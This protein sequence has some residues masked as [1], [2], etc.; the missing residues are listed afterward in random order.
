MIVLDHARLLLFIVP[1]LGGA[2][3]GYLT[4]ALAIRM[5][6]RPL[7]AYRIGRLR[8]PFTPGIIPRQRGQLADSIARMVGSTLLTPEALQ[9][10]LGRPAMR[11]AVRERVSWYTGRILS[12]EFQP[13]SESLAA[14]LAS[15]VSSPLFAELL[16]RGTATLVER[17]SGIQIADLSGVFRGSPNSK[18]RRRCVTALRHAARSGSRHLRA[19]EQPAAAYLPDTLVQDLA[20]FA[21][22]HY[23]ELWQ[24]VLRWLRTPHMQ[25]E[26]SSRGRVLLKRILQRLKFLQRF[27]VTAGQYD[28]NLDE[29]MP[30]IVRDLVQQL[31]QTVFKPETR[32]LILDELQVLV[33]E[34]LDCRPGEL[35]QRLDIDLEQL[36][37]RLV[38]QLCSQ[39]GVPAVT[40]GDIL[41]ATGLGTPQQ[42]AGQAVQRLLH[43]LGVRPT[44][45]AVEVRRRV[46]QRMQQL[47][48]DLLP[49]RIRIAGFIALTDS[50]KNR[51]DDFLCDRFFRL[52]EAK[53]PQVVQ[54]V[55]FT[56][57]VRDKVNGLDVRQVEQLLL[58]VMQRHL[59]FINL[60]GALLGAVIGSGQVVLTLLL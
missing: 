12:A 7:R 53:L 28:R 38:V 29:Q 19:L 21:D 3:I 16:Q 8:I 17:L 31:E 42:A 6:F 45:D 24:R 14:P 9:Q 11:S 37:D 36:A 56:G 25:Q 20:L 41:A 48:T 60:F 39:S 34:L 44:G 55:D 57:L 46:E 26:L 2:I 10:H 22:R 35:E 49:G 1:P 15:A 32:R 51:L 33:R 13:D 59:K 43:W 5:L 30:Y 52:A 54:A 27:V 50:Q 47:M 23:N 40:A 18:T 58:L 4:N